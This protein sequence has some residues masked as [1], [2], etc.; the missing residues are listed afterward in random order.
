MSGPPASWP[1]CNPLLRLLGY[2]PPPRPDQPPPWGQATPRDPARNPQLPH[3]YPLPPRPRNEG[4]GAPIRHGFQ[5]PGKPAS[6]PSQLQGGPLQSAPASR[7]GE[8][9]KTRLHLSLSLVIRALESPPIPSYPFPSP[10]IACILYSTA[11]SITQRSYCSISSTISQLYDL[12]LA[13]PHCSHL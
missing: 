7:P 1:Q 5:I 12:H 6:S 11:G 2:W 9:G 4:E 8:Y 13:K 3:L 10:S